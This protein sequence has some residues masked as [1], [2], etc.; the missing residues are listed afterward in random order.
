MELPDELKYSQIKALCELTGLSPTDLPND[1]DWLVLN[2]E[3]ADECCADYI[4]EAVWAFNA[5]FLASHSIA[6]QEVFEAIQAND[7]CEDNNGAILRLITD[8]DHFIEDAIRCDGRG[9]FMSS[10]DGNETELGHGIF[11]YRLN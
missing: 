1:D 7:K 11:V 6:D 3:Q 2:D 5:S 9:H 4:K 10:Y 8:V